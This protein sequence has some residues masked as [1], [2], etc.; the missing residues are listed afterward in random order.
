MKNRLVR[1]WE[2]RV[3]IWS[4]HFLHVSLL[5]QGKKDG[6]E[7]VIPEQ[8]VPPQF[9]S[10]AGTVALKERLTWSRCCIRGQKPVL[11]VPNFLAL[12]HRLCDSGRIR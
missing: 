7:E 2:K 8:V 4:F 5:R 10:D 1:E 11:K 9:L 12:P 6:K 3:K